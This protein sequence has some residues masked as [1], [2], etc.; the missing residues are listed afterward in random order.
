MD[1]KTS[2]VWQYVTLV[3][4]GKIK[5]N[6]CQKQFQFTHGA[7]SNMR[8]HLRTKHPTVDLGDSNERFQRP[9][10]D[11]D[12]VQACDENVGHV[13]QNAVNAPVTGPPQPQGIYIYI[14]LLLPTII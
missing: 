6:L 8:K 11:E 1:K 2:P 10:N 9:I 14:T 4:T 13:H 12:E 7:V 5:C 3:G